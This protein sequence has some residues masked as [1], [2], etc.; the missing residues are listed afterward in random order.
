MGAAADGECEVSAM[1]GFARNDVGGGGTGWEKSG[2]RRQRFFATVDL[3][4][5][6]TKRN[7]EK[8]AG[9]NI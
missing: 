4:Q 9:P 6:R 1:V 8:S 7:T 3:N 2:R 5:N